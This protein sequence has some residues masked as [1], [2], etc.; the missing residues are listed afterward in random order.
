MDTIQTDYQS[1]SP[2]MPIAAVAKALG[3][4]QSRF[5]EHISALIEEFKLTL[6]LHIDVHDPKYDPDDLNAFVLKG[7][8]LYISDFGLEIL[9]EYLCV[10]DHLHVKRITENIDVGFV[11]VIDDIDNNKRKIGKTKKP[12]VRI[13]SVCSSAG[14]KNK[15]VFL[16][17]RVVNYSELEKVLKDSFASEHIHGEWFTSSFDEIVALL[18][19]KEVRINPVLEKLKTIF[20]ESHAAD[21]LNGIKN[22]V[23]WKACPQH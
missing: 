19:Q 18:K 10:H 2:V 5:D 20:D 15:K 4:T 16:S 23:G 3:Y 7:E 9:F 21:F 8:K 1:I 14:V 17:N 6:G 22:F 12:T 13:A 11:Y